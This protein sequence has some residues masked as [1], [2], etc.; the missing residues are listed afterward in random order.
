M[1]QEVRAGRRDL[2][3]LRSCILWNLCPLEVILGIERIPR[4]NDVTI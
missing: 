2:S 3:G 1:G 4:R